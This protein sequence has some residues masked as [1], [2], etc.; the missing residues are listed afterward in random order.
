MKH[1]FSPQCKKLEISYR[2]KNGKQKQVKTKQHATK[3][4]NGQQRN[5]REIRIYFETNET[6]IQLSKSMGCTKA[7]L[8]GKFIVIQAYLM[9]QEKFQI[10]NITYHLKELEKQAK[11]KVSK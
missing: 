3:K 8:R 6:K 11:P 5:Q 1:F 7:T 9:K 2:K 4:T 10:S